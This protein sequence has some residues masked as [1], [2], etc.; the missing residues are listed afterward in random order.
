MPANPT[1]SEL[2]GDAWRELSGYDGRIAATF[3]ALLHP[4]KLTLEYLQGRRAR[5]LSP[6]RLY[7]AV[8]V[9]YFLIAAAAPETGGGLRV[10]VTQTGRDS[11]AVLT[12]EDRAEILAELDTTHWLMRPMLQSLVEDGGEGF[13]ARMFTIMPRVFFA[14][15]PLFAA[16]VA[17]FYR[18]R[19]FPAALVYAVHVHT[20][21]FLIFTLSE[22]AKFSGSRVVEGAI[23]IVTIIGFA[24]YAVRSLRAVF[25]GGWA[26]TL[27]KSA[28]IGVAYLIVAA[29]AFFLILILASLV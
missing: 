9:I 1:V 23:A 6:M 17:L 11:S 19:R 14:M 28:G 29:P 18:G 3:R 5:Y 25:G 8:S 26:A 7:L 21:A 16:I 4:G 22:A 27:A 12:E 10:G 15:L 13:R 2:T 24:I 20:F